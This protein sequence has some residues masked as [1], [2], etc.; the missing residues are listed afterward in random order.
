[1]RTT[2]KLLTTGMMCILAMTIQLKQAL[3]LDSAAYLKIVDNIRENIMSAGYRTCYAI[4][5][6]NGDT[7]NDLAIGIPYATVGGMRAAG[8]VIVILGNRFGLPGLPTLGAVNLGNVM[9]YSQAGPNGPNKMP[10]ANEAGDMVGFSLAAGDFNGDG[11]MDLA[12]G[13]PGEDRPD[14]A[15]A[16]VVFIGVGVRNSGLDFRNPGTAYAQDGSAKFDLRG[17]TNAGDL[18]GFSLAA[19]KFNND[20]Y[21]DLAIGVPGEDFRH[22]GETRRDAGCVVI[23]MGGDAVLDGRSY[24]QAF[25]RVASGRYKL[26][27]HPGSGNLLGFSLAVG[28]FNGDHLD[29][30]AIGIP[31]AD[32]EEHDK[33]G[34]VS[35]AQGMNDGLD[36]STIHNSFSQA[37]DGH[38][39]LRGS[40]TAGELTGF[41]LAAG[42]FN[43]DGY[44][45]LAI[46]A[47]GETVDGLRNAGAV[48]VARGGPAEP[49]NGSGLNGGWYLQQFTQS[50]GDIDARYDLPGTAE[51]GDLFGF[52]LAVGDFNYTSQYPR[53]DLAIGVPGENSG[54]GAV[55]IRFGSGTGGIAS[56]AAPVY[57]SQS[58]PTAAEDLE[59]GSETGDL[60]GLSLAAGKFGTLTSAA[61]VISVPGER[62]PN[63]TNGIA[64]ASPF[65]DMM[66]DGFT[67]L[68][69]GN[70]NVGPNAATER[71]FWFNRYTAGGWAPFSYVQG[72]TQTQADLILDSVRS[73]SGIHI[74]RT[75][76]SYSFKPAM[77]GERDILDI[78]LDVAVR[79]DLLPDPSATFNL[80]VRPDVGD[81][82]ILFRVDWDTTSLVLRI[83]GSTSNLSPLPFDITPA[84]VIL[85]PDRSV[86]VVI[87]P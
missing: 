77:T 24:E 27:G 57:L 14:A 85:L 82:G 83:S 13:A 46:G 41:S 16:G 67:A 50:M 6:F 55:M 43:G 71:S 59:G 63:L 42:D 70:A 40:V 7:Y 45:D 51:E 86:E 10:G 25:S 49:G 18:L 30:L 61:L 21:W 2:T 74:D 48:V 81:G 76:D 62:V 56:A 38:F 44:A 52:S 28:D 20:Q 26:P 69:Y 31:G 36:A 58:R 78:T 12:V 15:D 87:I 3:A 11:I 23:A 84:K 32:P 60:V 73:S 53:A 64:L 19:G 66:V 54:Q 29:D 72:Q 79:I 75:G 80:H 22:D 34:G 65:D 37:A 4:G 35:V 9:V 8:K 5:D 39:N 68:V 47:P 1:M 33:A 17:E